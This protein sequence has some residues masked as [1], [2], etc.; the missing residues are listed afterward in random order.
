MNRKWLVGGMAILCGAFTVLEV[1]R[2]RDEYV[3]SKHLWNEQAQEAFLDAVGVELERITNDPSI[4]NFF[5]SGGM[6]AYPDMPDSVFFNSE[7]GGRFY[8][9]PKH[10]REHAY[11]KDGRRNG[12]LTSEL[13]KRPFHSDSL[14]MVWDKLLA[15][16]HVEAD[17]RVVCRVASLEKADTLLFCSESEGMSQRADSLVSTYM[18][19][20]LET[21]VSGYVAYPEWKKWLSGRMVGLVLLWMVYGC[22]VYFYDPLRRMAVCLLGMQKRVHRPQEVLAVPVREAFCPKGKRNYSLGED[23]YF[24]ATQKVICGR[25]GNSLMLSDTDTCL[26]EAFL[27]AEDRVLDK[28][29]IYEAIGK[30][31]ESFSL[32]SYYKMMSRFRKRMEKLPFVMVHNCGN[33]SY[34][35]ILSL[36][37]CENTL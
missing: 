26:L 29:H 8:Q 5:I 36:H 19:Y 2:L 17:T 37:S 23:F 15:D 11:W 9:L 21:E 18:G 14:R 4:R 31:L 10:R 16:A 1:S 25:D 27:K 33:G 22:F 20:C 12:L 28:Y 32:D 6:L 24:D 7:N 30:R 13:A 34:Q 3:E 35:L